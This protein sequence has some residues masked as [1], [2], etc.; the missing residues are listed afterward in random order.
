MGR[1][2]CSWHILRH[3]LCSL[4]T[5][6]FLWSCTRQTWCK[7]HTLLDLTW[8]WSEISMPFKYG[9][10]KESPGSPYLDVKTPYPG[11]SLFTIL[12]GILN[13]LHN[14][15]SKMSIPHLKGH[16]FLS[17]ALNSKDCRTVCMQ[18]A[19]LHV[20]L[21]ISV[22]HQGCQGPFFPP[23][24]TTLDAVN[25]RKMLHSIS[26]RSSVLHLFLSKIGNKCISV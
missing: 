25:M 9:K 3:N 8:V 18:W 5:K 4:F 24:N 26:L 13:L 2:F 17:S 11:G 14:Y 1:S 19:N 7:S 22:H 23:S 6:R 20:W 21:W 12:N 16:L 15:V 10:Q